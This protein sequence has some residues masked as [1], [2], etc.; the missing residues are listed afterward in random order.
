[1]GGRW[2][3]KA[4]ELESAYLLLLICWVKDIW[5]DLGVPILNIVIFLNVSAFVK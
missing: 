3:I 4:I 1:M 2:F 5:L